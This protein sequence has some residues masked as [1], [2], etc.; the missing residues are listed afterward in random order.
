MELPGRS[1]RSLLV[2][3]LAATAHAQFDQFAWTLQGSSEGSGTLSADAMHLVSPAG[4]FGCPSG[5]EV[6][7][8]T[9]TTAGGIVSVHFDWDNQ[10]GCFGWWLVDAPFFR[11]GTETTFVD[12]GL[13]P[14][15][16]YIDFEKDV[17]FHVPAGTLLAFGA[18]SADCDCGPG[19]LDLTAFAFEPDVWSELGPGLAGVA[20]TPSLAGLGSLQAGT[21][22]TFSLVDCTPSAPAFL[23]MGPAP[24]MAPFKGGV[25]VPEPAQLAAL[26][27]S[28]AGRIILIGTWPAGVPSGLQLVLQYWIED[29]AGPA[30]WSASNGLVAS[31]P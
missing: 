27:T 16:E 26:T 1:F 29:A 3:L 9:V 2:L 14:G 5:N 21:S 25:L 18:W 4:S 23:V 13:G 22:W 28:P 7:F 31:V 30:G 20:G 24:L 11:V 17:S 15:F 10:D 8:E 19:V 6:W 12:S